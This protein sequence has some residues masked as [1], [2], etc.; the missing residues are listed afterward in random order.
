MKFVTTGQRI[1]NGAYFVYNII[2]T[3][4]MAQ[5]Q[6]LSYNLATRSYVMR[7]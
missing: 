6:H 7:T 4:T 3:V 1:N 2:S 5:K